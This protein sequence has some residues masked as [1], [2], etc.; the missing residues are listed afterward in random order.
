VGALGAHAD[1]SK[2]N[3]DAVIGARGS[4]DFAKNF[5][6]FGVFDIGAG[7]SDLTLQAVGGFGYRFEWFNLVAAYR[8]MGWDFGNDVKV[9]DDMDIQGPVLGIQF[10]F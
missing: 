6:L 3:W 7:D 10:T 2:S 1:D 5:F 4:V 9:L 8:Y